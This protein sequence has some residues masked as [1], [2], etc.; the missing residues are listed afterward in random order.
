[1]LTTQQILED[2][3]SPKNRFDRIVLV[4]PDHSLGKPDFRATEDAFARFL[5][6]ARM[7]PSEMI[8]QTRMPEHAIWDYLKR[9][10]TLGFLEK[11]LNERRE[12]KLPPEMSLGVLTVRAKKEAAALAA[13]KKAWRA[14]KRSLPKEEHLLEVFEPR[15]ARPFKLRGRFRYQM[16]IKYHQLEKVGEAIRRIIYRR[17]SGVIMTFDPAMYS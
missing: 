4:A 10:D 12:L 15:P 2:G 17:E 7:N 3:G 11:E 8:V 5:A 6:L 1:M 9:E 16:L 14:V 13:A